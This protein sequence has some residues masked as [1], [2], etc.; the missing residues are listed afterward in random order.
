M[1]NAFEPARAA[2]AKSDTEAGVRSFINGVI[3]NGAFDRLPSPAREMMLDNGAEMRLET[4]TPSEQYFSRISPNDVREL[5]HACAAGRGSP[6]PDHVRP[7]H[8]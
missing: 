2:F 4:M 5:S 8:R 7:D 1:A 6:E 3:G